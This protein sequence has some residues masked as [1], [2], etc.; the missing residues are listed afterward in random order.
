VVGSCI[1]SQHAANADA[2]RR[3]N[4]LADLCAGTDSRGVSTIV[5]SS[6]LF[7]ADDGWASDARSNA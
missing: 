7:C 1:E 3:V 5:P 4:V 6:T 2:A